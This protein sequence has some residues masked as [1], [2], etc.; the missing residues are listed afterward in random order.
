MHVDL[1]GTGNTQTSADAEPGA[2]QGCTGKAHGDQQDRTTEAAMNAVGIGEPASREDEQRYRLTPRC[3]GHAFGVEIMLVEV[4]VTLLEAA[5]DGPTLC[6]GVH[7][8]IA[9]WLKSKLSI[10]GRYFFKL[11]AIKIHLIAIMFSSF[12]KCII[13]LRCGVWRGASINS[14]QLAED[15]WTCWAG[16]CLCTVMCIE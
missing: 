5:Q 8:N 13:Q 14:L 12:Q 11:V 4:A 3:C 7:N 2:L 1:G 6:V 15:S 10:C 16:F 9:S